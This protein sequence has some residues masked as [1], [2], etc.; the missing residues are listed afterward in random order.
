MR[1]MQLIEILDLTW[2]PGSFRDATTDTLQVILNLGNFYKPIV[3]RLRRALEDAQTRRVLD[4][5]SGG[6]GPWLR[7]YRV[8]EE[9]ENF[10]L[11]ICLTDKYP[12]LGA[13]HHARAASRNKINFHADPVDATQI[14]DE[15][16]GFRTL[17]TS[18]HHFPPQEARAILQNAVDTQQGIGVF[19]VA[20]RHPLTIFFVLLLPIVAFVLTPF[21]R[22]FRW[23]RVVW[24]LIPIIPF[25]LLF[26]G[27]VSC[28]RTYSPQELGELTEGLSGNIY[29]WKVGCEKASLSPI[30]ITYLIG[31]PNRKQGSTSRK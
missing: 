5:C 11:A 20:R 13:F 18:F 15:L 31:H 27:I 7:L 16:E 12:N 9:E 28:L 25:V 17:F 2:F 4:L 30:S 29:R 6:G 1:R 23:S 21:V 26:D 3:P 8:F 14:P 24:T 19:E 10:P 22:P